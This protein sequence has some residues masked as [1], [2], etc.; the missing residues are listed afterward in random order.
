MLLPPAP[1]KD[2]AVGS[3]SRAASSE[4]E[5]PPT[6]ADPTE[7]VSVWD[8]AK[9]VVRRHAKRNHKRTLKAEIIRDLKRA[10]TWRHKWSYDY[11]DAERIDN[12]ENGNSPLLP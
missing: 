1:A 3:G 2:N 5:V 12:A 9:V 11:D 4:D 8:L 10:I 7:V 6:T